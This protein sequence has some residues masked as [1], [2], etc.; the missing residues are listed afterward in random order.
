MHNHMGYNYSYGY[1]YGLMKFV[2][3][4]ASHATI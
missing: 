4:L 1:V 3:H 2:G